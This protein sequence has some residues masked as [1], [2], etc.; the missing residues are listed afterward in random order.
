[1]LSRRSGIDWRRIVAF[2]IIIRRRG[3]YSSSRSAIRCSWCRF[4]GIRSMITEHAYRMG[5]V[6]SFAT[7]L[8]VAGCSVD[9]S[10]SPAAPAASTQSAADA[11]TNLPI[12]PSG[13]NQSKDWPMWRGPMG[14]GISTE[15]DWTSDWP[16][17]GPKKL[18][19]RDVVGIG[20]SSCAVVGDFLYT[21]GHDPNTPEKEKAGELTDD[22]VL[23]MDAETGRRIW[24]Y[25]YA[26]K[27]VADL[28][29]GGPARRRPSMATVSIRLARKATCSAST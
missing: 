7:C 22:H 20:F 21:L 1:M 26:C 3:S 16:A 28:N 8:I 23:C 24:E 13:P 19:S 14:N 29:E 5:T 10:G 4:L 9:S 25:R 18:W 15:T 12:A 11:S 2:T 6:V 17:E 27:Q